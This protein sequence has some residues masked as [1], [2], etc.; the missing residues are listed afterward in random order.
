MRPAWD[1]LNGLDSRFAAQAAL[2]CSDGEGIGHAARTFAAAAAKASP[3]GLANGRKG[4]S[5][6]VFAVAVSK[7]VRARP[8]PVF[9]CSISLNFIKSGTFVEIS[10]KISKITS[11]IPTFATIYSKMAPNMLFLV[12]IVEIYDFSTNIT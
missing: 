1:G 9:L 6:A 11:K 10:A 3:S 5:A 4:V 7:S 12:E 8:K 2:A